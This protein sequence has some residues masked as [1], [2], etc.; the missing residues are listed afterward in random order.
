MG[1]RMQHVAV[2]LLCL[3]LYFLTNQ[4]YGQ[5][6]VWSFNVVRQ[7]LIGTYYEKITILRKNHYFSDNDD[8]Y[9]FDMDDDYIVW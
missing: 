5:D 7:K 2:S 8:H 4:I 3:W 6:R 9:D 1:F